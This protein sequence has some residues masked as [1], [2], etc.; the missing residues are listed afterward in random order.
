MCTISYYPSEDGFIMTQNRDE[1]PKRGVSGLA[2]EAGILFPKDIESSGTWIATDALGRVISLMNG[3]FIPHEP[4]QLIM[5]SRGSIISDLLKQDDII[6]TVLNMNLADVEPFTLLIA[7]TGSLQCVRW[8]GQ[9]K[10]IDTL[11]HKEPHFWSSS[12]LY[13]PVWQERR[14]IWF[15]AWL[16]GRM[17]VSASDLRW[18]HNYGGEGDRLYDLIMDRGTVCTTSITQVNVTSKSAIM[19]FKDLSTCIVEEK[20]L[21]VS[22]QE[23]AR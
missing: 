17:E 10:H 16:D 12:M 13:P 1:S 7:E 21:Q 18:F 11:D 2:L 4:S 22:Q 6:A 19:R 9:E 5:K 14:K 20:R 3:A 15:M 23:L 8:D